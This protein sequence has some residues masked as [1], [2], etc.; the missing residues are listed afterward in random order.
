MKDWLFITQAEDY[1]LDSWTY[2]DWRQYVARRRD[3]SLQPCRV[4]GLPGVLAAIGFFLMTPIL[5]ACLLH[6]NGMSSEQLAWG[7]AIV[8]FFVGTTL[9]VPWVICWTTKW[10][11][12]TAVAPRSYDGQRHF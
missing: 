7:R 9:C 4:S 2:G 5:F 8:S 3:G 12:M 10:E 11:I 6:W 1:W